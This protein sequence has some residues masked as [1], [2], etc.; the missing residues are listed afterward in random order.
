MSYSTISPDD[1]RGREIL[2]KAVQEARE[3]A[4]RKRGMVKPQVQQDIHDFYA[5]T[6]GIHFSGTKI[7][8]HPRDHKRITAKKKRIQEMEALG[9]DQ[10]IIDFAKRELEKDLTYLLAASYRAP[11]KIEVADHREEEKK[12]GLGARIKGIFGK[13]EDSEEVYEYE[14][15]D[16][17]E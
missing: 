10:E 17:D 4:E 5:G 8:V 11:K 12:E 3:E 2:R 16:E 14:V 7:K 6:D 13:S 9:I 15:V 1:I